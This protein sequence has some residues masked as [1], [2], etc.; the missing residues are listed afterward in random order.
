VIYATLPGVDKSTVNERG[1]KKRWSMVFN[2]AM[3]K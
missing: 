2:N 1:E 3:Q